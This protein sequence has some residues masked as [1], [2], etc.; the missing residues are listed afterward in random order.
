MVP[1]TQ[2]VGNIFLFFPA[3][4][5][6]P[7]ARVTAMSSAFRTIGARCSLT[8]QRISVIVLNKFE[9]LDVVVLV[10]GLDPIRYP[11]NFIVTIFVVA[12]VRSIS[13]VVAVIVV[14]A[15]F[16]VVSAAITCS[17]CGALSWPRLALQSIASAA[18]LFP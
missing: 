5:T 10:S 4:S 13:F 18:G 3:A 8:A 14:V 11:N 9:D 7:A 1:D 12:F 6:A 16:V 2:S 15:I 17:G